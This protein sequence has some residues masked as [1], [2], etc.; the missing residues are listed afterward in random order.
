MADRKVYTLLHIYDTSD[1]VGRR[2][3]E[4]SRDDVYS[5]AVSSGVSELMEKF[6]DLVE[7]GKFFR[8]AVFTTHG[9]AGRI[10]F[11]HQ[12]IDA[13]RLYKLFNEYR[14]DRVFPFQNS[15][16]YFDGCNVADG[17]DGWEF[18][19]AAARTFFRSAGGNVFG[20]TSKGLG[21]PSII[22][23]IGG[24]TEHL[25]G[26]IRGVVITPADDGGAYLSRWES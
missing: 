14:Y 16:M 12:R 11:N 23:F 4:A 13:K 25:W 20:W 9:G 22:P 2:Q 19:E 8:R 26:D 5:I 21:M 18:L 24:H 10:S 7:S 1:W 6:N 3:Y 15:R 17:D